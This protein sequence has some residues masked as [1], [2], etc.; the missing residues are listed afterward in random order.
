MVAGV[1]KMNNESPTRLVHSGT[2][3]VVVFETIPPMWRRQ[4]WLVCILPGYRLSKTE[5]IR[6]V[7]LQ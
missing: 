6:H 4:G 5:I 7:Y 2:N 3:K 1:K